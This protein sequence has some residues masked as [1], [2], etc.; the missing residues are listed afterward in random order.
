MIT[1]SLQ[2]GTRAPA[3][4]VLSPLRIARHGSAQ[5]GPR[6]QQGTWEV[7]MV[8]SMVSVVHGR[9]VAMV[10]EWRSNGFRGTAVDVAFVGTAMHWY[11]LVGIWNKLRNQI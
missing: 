6:C 7:T 2:G 1:C 11:E 5:K 9:A 8:A 4:L 3:L 10:T